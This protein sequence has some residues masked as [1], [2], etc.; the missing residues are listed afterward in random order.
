M[1]YQRHHRIISSRPTGGIFISSISRE[2]TRTELTKVNKHRIM[3]LL[4][5]T[6]KDVIFPTVKP[7]QLSVNKITPIVVGETLNSNYKH[8]KSS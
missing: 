3:H 5:I 8:E 2:K 4:P 1:S 6:C 7:P